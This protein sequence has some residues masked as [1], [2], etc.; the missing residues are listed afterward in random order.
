MLC[1]FTFEGRVYKVSREAYDQ[2]GNIQLPDGRVLEVDGW[3]ESSPPRPIISG[4]ATEEQ[5]AESPIFEAAA[6]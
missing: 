1:S 2:A 4:I 6:V 5:V 3:L